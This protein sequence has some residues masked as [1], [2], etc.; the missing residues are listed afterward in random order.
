M[1]EKRRG[2]GGKE[3]EQEREEGGASRRPQTPP[4]P[5]RPL[6]D[7][8]PPQGPPDKPKPPRA[9][10]GPRA[11][12]RAPRPRQRPP[13]PVRDRRQS[14]PRSPA[15]PPE[16]ARS[17]F[18]SG[19]SARPGTPQGRCPPT[20]SMAAAPLPPLPRRPLEAARTPRPRPRRP[21]GR[22]PRPPAPASAPIGRIP[23]PRLSIG[24][25]AQ[26]GPPPSRRKPALGPARAYSH[27]S[28]LPALGAHWLSSSGTS[29]IFRFSHWLRVALIPEGEVETGSAPW[30]RGGLVGKGAGAG[31]SRRSGLYERGGACTKGAGLARGTLAR[32][33][34]ESRRG[35][36]VS[37][38]GGWG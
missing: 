27:W 31:L 1:K 5:P 19:P 32:G 6:K 26:R 20:S 23:L 10:S 35:I 3:K 17:R 29:G 25:C 30:R 28:S 34:W 12:L 9:P 7:P 15:L 8:E 37:L 4:G 13:S 36:R 33:Q 24:C 21:I 38:W 18:P 11:P 16:L 14:Q 22:P 2:R